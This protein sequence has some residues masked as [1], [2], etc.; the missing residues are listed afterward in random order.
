MCVEWGQG[1]G[2]DNG[3]MWGNG[4]NEGHRCII[5]LFLTLSPP[6]TKTL[7]TPP[8]FITNWYIHCPKQLHRLCPVL[9]RSIC[10]PYP[11]QVGGA[12]RVAVGVE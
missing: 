6:K 11:G 4:V 2:E 10:L 5:I 8:L 3:R 7:L 9:L 12:R 1:G